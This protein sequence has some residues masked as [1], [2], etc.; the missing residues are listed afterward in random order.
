LAIKLGGGCLTIIIDWKILIF[1]DFDNYNLNI[2]L[3]IGFL[4]I[5]GTRVLDG[6]K[7]IL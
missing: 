6:L 2:S 5:E 4:L 7:E 3:N 1:I